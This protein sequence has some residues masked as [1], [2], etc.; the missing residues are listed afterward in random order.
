[1]AIPIPDDVQMDKKQAN[2]TASLSRVKKKR[3][4]IAKLKRTPLR[5]IP[6]D[7]NPYKKFNK[8]TIVSG[9]IAKKTRT[10]TRKT[11]AAVAPAPLMIVEN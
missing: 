7:N 3:A 11:A 8:N 5:Y 9:N 4:E 1:M 6:V 10:R 2:R